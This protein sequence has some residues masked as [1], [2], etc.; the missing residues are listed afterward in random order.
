MQKKA[1]KN[2]KIYVRNEDKRIKDISESKNQEEDKIE[3]REI[4][5][6]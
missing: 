6:K 2:K 5:S 3:N 4:R 1:N